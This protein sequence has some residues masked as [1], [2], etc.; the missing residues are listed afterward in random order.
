MKQ[1]KKKRIL[2]FLLALAVATS[3]TSSL[4]MTAFAQE[5]S[6]S[7][8]EENQNVEIPAFDEEETSKEGEETEEETEEEK[9]EKEMIDSENEETTEQENAAGQESESTSDVLPPV[10]QPLPPATLAPAYTVTAATQYSNVQIGDYV[11]NLDDSNSTA[12]VIQFAPQD[13]TNTTFC[14]P[15]QVEYN[16][17]EYTVTTIGPGNSTSISGTYTIVDLRNINNANIKSYAFRLT[18]ITTVYLG[19]VEQIGDMAFVSC[20][21]LTTVTLSGSVSIGNLAF[22]GCPQLETFAADG[23]NAKVVSIADQA[24]YRDESLKNFTVNLS[25]CETIGRSAFENCTAL[26]INELNLASI[27]S[28]GASAFKSCPGIQKVV[29][30]EA[31]EVTIGSYAFSNSLRDY[32][33]EVSNLAEVV[34]LTSATVIGDSAFLGCKNLKQEVD[35]QKCTSLGEA[36]F[37]DSGITK[38]ILPTTDVKIPFYGFD[39]CTSLTMVENM[40]SVVEIS[41]YGFRGAPLTDMKNLDLSNCSKLGEAALSSTGIETVKLQK[42]IT[43]IPDELF[44]GCT[45]FMGFTSGEDCLQWEDI[46]QIGRQSFSQTDL[47]NLTVNLLDC[48]D[49]GEGAFSSSNLTSVIWP[50]T[51]TEIPASVF[52]SCPN[53]IG[54]DTSTGGLDWKDITKIGSFAFGSD[55]SIDGT[56]DLQNC[57][58]IGYEAFRSCQNLDQ[59]VNLNA[60]NSETGKG[61]IISES[62]FREC[63]QLGQNNILDLSMCSSINEYAFAQSGVRTIKWTS[64]DSDWKVVDIADGVFYQCKDFTG[65]DSVD[66]NMDW[67]DFVT[68]GN[69]SFYQCSSITDLLELSS[70]TAIGNYAFSGVIQLP[71]FILTDGKNTTIGNYAFQGCSNL[72]GDNNV[73]NIAMCNSIGKYAFAQS[74]VVQVNYPTHITLLPEGVFQQ[75]ANFI[76]FA[77][78]GF[79]FKDIVSVGNYAC[80][81]CTSLPETPDLTQCQYIGDAAFESCENITGPMDLTSAIYI[82]AN[83]FNG[84]NQ[85]IPTITQPSVGA[86]AFKGAIRIFINVFSEDTLSDYYTNTSIPVPGLQGQIIIAQIS[87]NGYPAGVPQTN[88]WI[89]TIT[90]PGTYYMQVKQNS[91]PATGVDNYLPDGPSYNIGLVSMD[92]S[93]QTTPVYY[94]GPFTVSVPV[95]SYDPSKSYKFAVNG[96]LQENN[97]YPTE[98]NGSYTATCSLSSLPTD[99]TVIALEYRNVVV[100]NDITIQGPE[101]D[102][103]IYGDTDKLTAIVSPNDAEDK[104]IIWSSSN[105]DILSIDPNTGDIIAKGVGD[106]E[107]SATAKTGGYKTTITLHVSP[108]TLHMI[109]PATINPNKEYDKTTTANVIDKG[110]VD[111]SG[112]LADDLTGFD[113]K[114]IASYDTPDIGDNKT[115]S[116]QYQP[117]NPNYTISDQT[118]VDGS[119]TKRT[120]SLLTPA[121]I[122]TQKDYDKTTDVQINS[123]GVLD[124]SSILPGDSVTITGVTA[125]YDDPNA[126]TD[127][128]ITV[129][130]TLDNPNYQVIDQTV[131][132]SIDPI[133]LTV[134]NVD[135][136]TEK[137]FDGTNDAT[138]IKDGDLDTSNALEGDNVSLKE[139]SAY[140]EDANAGENKTIH[141]TFTLDTTNYIV[142][143]QTRTDGVINPADLNGSVVIKGTPAVDETLS[144]DATDLLTNTPGVHEDDLLPQ[145]QF[146][147][148]NSVW[149]DIKDANDFTLVLTENNLGDYIRVVVTPKPSAINFVPTSMVIS[150]ETKPVSEKIIYPDDNNQ[151][152]NNS[153]ATNLDNAEYDANGKHQSFNA[154]S[155]SAKTKDPFHL[156]GA[157]A[158][159]GLSSIAT[160]LFKKRKK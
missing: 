147:K 31:K 30:P 122:E 51:V 125:S 45:S 77:N 38:V 64:L 9:H 73:L 135:I 145:W 117:T 124:E 155:S 76:G 136:E 159:L 140:Y 126:G 27:K 93:G 2:A 82:G 121:S 120:L 97:V 134:S 7:S 92:F 66:T 83:A 79:D 80:Q 131:P 154:T 101:N 44:A 17:V 23:V 68:I 48:Q 123:D 52:L 127:K 105:P 57:V 132:A 114:V 103:Y 118:T 89:E 148:D 35:L 91:D 16:E 74:G 22:S 11:Y 41:N 139:T 32:S 84:A 70:C 54:F 85:I 143:E 53:F 4:T 42:T 144:I 33:I 55:N 160:I 40:S 25:S 58:F 10:D 47:T 102:T 153:N 63:Y 75:C 36:A 152:P 109:K 26:K 108:K 21:N 111:T 71:D 90:Q 50:K 61:P 56:L 5:N 141:I 158:T 3:S 39:G 12:Q 34:N 157:L 78:E 18:D 28:I 142:I 24:F 116:V 146:S 59:F 150:P 69:Y 104:T 137:T 72:T 138:V 8:S 151:N 110:V 98:S 86:D 156:A 149:T 29:L 87:A 130:Y 81:E 133:V 129:S 65:F 113:Y 119:I 1:Y 6:P 128:T 112:V 67:N 15:S 19:N 100:V 43:Q 96:V 14:P 20:K 106:A 60:T 46:T 13:E 62:A 99:R 95:Q 49:I 88:E 94:D 107:I 37:K 115:I